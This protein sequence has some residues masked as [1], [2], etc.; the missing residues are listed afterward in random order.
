MT[1][2]IIGRKLNVRDS[3]KELVEKKLEKLGADVKCI[4]YENARHEILN[5]INREEV[6]ADIAAWIGSKI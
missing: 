2:N 4:I 1:I 5:E 6:F 3:F